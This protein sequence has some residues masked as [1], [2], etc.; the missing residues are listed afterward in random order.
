MMSDSRFICGYFLV[1]LLS[2]LS[3]CDNSLEDDK[4]YAEEKTIESFIST[5]K[6]TYTKSDGVYH[7]ATEPSYGYEVNDGDTVKFW[8][9]GY[10]LS[11]LVFE[12]NVESVAIEENLNTEVRSF[13]PLRVIAGETDLITGLKRGLLLTRLNQTSTIIFTSD[14]GFK[15][16]IVGPIDAWSPLAYDIEVIYVNGKGIQTEKQLL[17]AMDLSSYNLH[18]TGLYYKYLIDTSSTRPVSTSTVYGWYK[19]TLPSG[20]VVEEVSTLNATINL[21]ETNMG[22]IKKG[23]MLLSLGGSAEFIAP[24]P[25]GYGKKGNDVVSPYQPIAISMRLDSIK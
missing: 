12:T 6:L 8:Y 13:E 2:F 25:M 7:I 18:S 9:V 16:Q 21:S 1:G 15:G 20:E 24:S 4:R 17:E 23:F 22:A 11:G 19:I 14:L 3:A 10:T 5:N